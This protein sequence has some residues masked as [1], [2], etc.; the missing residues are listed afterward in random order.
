M[1]THILSNPFILL[2]C[3]VLFWSGNFIV[4]RAVRFEIDPISLAFWRW[5]F[6]ALIALYL[7][8]KNIVH[9]IKE[10]YR[11]WHVMLLLSAT[12]VACFNTLVYLGLQSTVAINA[13]LMQ[14]MIPVLTVVL[15]FTL[16]KERMKVLQLVG[17]FISLCG[18][19]T[20][21]SKGDFS[22]LLGLQLNHGDGLVFLAVICYS[23]YSVSLRKR[24]KV[25]PLSFV[26]ASFVL[27]S[28][29][30]L[31]FHL[32]YSRALL[33]PINLPGLSAIAYVS[34]FPSIVSYLCYNRGVELAG[35]NKA[36][37]FIHLMPVFGSLMAI[38][39]LG[40]TLLS[41]H[42]IGIFCI[43]CGIYFATKRG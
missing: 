28:L 6:A 15:S 21:V 5:F 7:S 36:S 17:V 11:S 29:M 40:E 22:L 30:L 32:T 38:V 35:A 25:H 27:G 39:F 8:R 14:S 42:F 10:M 24:P 20:I 33:P 37:M 4:G 2:L 34:I 26:A 3:A 23:I 9:D 16:F 41:F 19:L 12:G 1:R 13:L 43:A 31:P 18:V